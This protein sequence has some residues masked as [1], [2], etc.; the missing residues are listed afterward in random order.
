MPIIGGIDMAEGVTYTLKTTVNVRISPDASTNSTKTG[1][2]FGEGE[3]KVVVET[4]TDK[5]GNLWGKTED[6]DVLNTKVQTML[7][8]R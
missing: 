4:T 7:L 2:T 8:L 5:N 1:R 3:T 6:G